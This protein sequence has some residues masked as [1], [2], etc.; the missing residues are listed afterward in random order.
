[1]AGWAKLFSSIITSSIWTEDDVTLR[2]WIAMLATADA[3][4]VVEGSLP[5]FASLA[6]VTREKLE[7]SL[8]KLVSPDPDS[9]TPDHE[10]R[11]TGAYHRLAF[12]YPDAVEAAVSGELRVP[13]YD[14]FAV[15]RFTRRTLYRTGNKYRQRE[16][17]EAFCKERGAGA[18]DGILLQAFSDLDDA[19]FGAQPEHLLVQLYGFTPEVKASQRPYVAAVART[20][21]ARFVGAL[22]HDQSR[23]VD[24]AVLAA[25][26]RAD[27]DD[28]FA[29]ACMKRL[30]GRGYDDAI[31]AYCKRRAGSAGHHAKELREILERIRS[32]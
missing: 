23:A 10:G 26:L 5:G 4:G 25:L 11:R 24:Q 15:E 6:R 30:V 31:E 20:A 29:L 12:F 13:T 21:Q 16:R 17:F 9:R 8:R 3:D 14:V 1:M 19:R 22:V 2:V 32:Q 18:R 28:Y 7:E 27:D